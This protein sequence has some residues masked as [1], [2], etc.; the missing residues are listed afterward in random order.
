VKSNHVSVY[1]RYC[2][3]NAIRILVSSNRTLNIQHIARYLTH[4]NSAIA[5]LGLPGPPQLPIVGSILGLDMQPL[6]PLKLTE[7]GK[8]YG[9]TYCYMEGGTPV[10]CTSNVGILNDVFVTKYNNFHDR[11]V[12]LLR[13]F[14]HFTCLAF[15]IRTRLRYE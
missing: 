11:K 14:S 1:L 5:K 3:V 8:M 7:W 15:P 12:V 6:L 2:N 13:H 4:R 10:I 9:E